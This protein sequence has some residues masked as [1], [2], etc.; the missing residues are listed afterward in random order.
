LSIIFIVEI[1]DI[2]NNLANMD[3]YKGLSGG[4]GVNLRGKRR[5]LGRA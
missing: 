4:E 2:L 1:G 5:V 3:V